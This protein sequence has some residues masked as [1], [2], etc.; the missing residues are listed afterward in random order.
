VD[1]KIGKPSGTCEKCQSDFAG[2]E[3][4]HSAI[5]DTGECFRRR[6]YCES[7]WE[8]G[9]PENAFSTW[10]TH[11]PRKEEQRLL[12]DDSVIFDFFNRLAGSDEPTRI[13]FRYIL[14][15]VLMRKRILKFENVEHRDDHDILVLRRAGTDTTYDVIDPKLSEDQIAQVQADIGQILHADVS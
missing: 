7:C 1:W 6:D 5:F 13:N 2:G 14:A 9:P 10:Q 12:V 15:L 4:Y 11:V 3:R 8:Q